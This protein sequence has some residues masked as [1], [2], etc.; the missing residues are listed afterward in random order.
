MPMAGLR[1]AT[2]GEP[3]E[4]NIKEGDIM[5]TDA[6]I[7]R[8][9]DGGT[10]PS[11]SSAHCDQARPALPACMPYVAGL[12]L[13]CSAV[14][15]VWQMI[16]SPVLPPS[17]LGI[18]RFDFVLIG[19][20]IFLGLWLFSGAFA[21][22]AR[23]AAI[24]C[25]AI[26]GLY[27]LYEAESGRADCGCFGQ[28]PVNPWITLTLD[29]T[30]LALL[31]LSGRQRSST[32][33]GAVHEHATKEN[34]IQTAARG[35]G[36]NHPPIR[37]LILP[38]I[39]AATVAIAVAVGTAILHTKPVR[40]ANGMATA[41]GGRIVILEPHQ[42]I[43]HRLPVLG[44]IIAQTGGAS[45]ADRLERGQWIVLFYHASCE[46]CQKAIP[47]YE[48][49]AARWK[50]DDGPLRVLFIGM[51]S[52]LGHPAAPKGLFNSKIALHGKL[53]ASHDWFATTPAAVELKDGTVIRAAA[54]MAA[55]N[56][57]WLR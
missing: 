36:G 27:T 56:L 31:A 10:R 8:E 13:L 32:R 28:V 18:T 6:T 25:F 29:T 34:G 21:G 15:K 3:T 17:P 55:M 23:L 38:V 9:K 54:D 57:H 53:D 41:D 52:E 7:M 43:G 40:A 22:T 2:H 33:C 39:A 37:R 47:V 14:L 16:Q 50:A 46:E 1:Q 51:P 12:I 42:W 5:T 4:T 24:L 26:F 35:N 19:V 11:A 44:Y 48:Q 49:A 45:L 20:E 30:I